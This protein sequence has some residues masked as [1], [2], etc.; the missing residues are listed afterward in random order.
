MLAT[1]FHRAGLDG[2]PDV[3]K[4]RITS[5]RGNSDVFASRYEKDE[6]N[7]CWDAVRIASILGTRERIANFG[8]LPVQ[9]REKQIRG[10]SAYKSLSFDHACIL[11]CHYVTDPDLVATEHGIFCYLFGCYVSGCQSLL[12]PETDVILPS[13]RL[14]ATA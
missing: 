13:K 8:R 5:M 3:F 12:T 4:A 7:A 1:V 14:G 2:L 11:A 10:L 9:Q 6:L